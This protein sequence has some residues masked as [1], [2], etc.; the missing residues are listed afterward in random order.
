MSF[1]PGL[2]SASVT[3][4]DVMS[5]L[6]GSQ[7]GSNGSPS[8][9]TTAAGWLTL[10]PTTADGISYGAPVLMRSVPVSDVAARSRIGDNNDPV[11]YK[12]NAGIYTYLSTTTSNTLKEFTSDDECIF[13]R[14][15]PSEILLQQLAGHVSSSY[16][17]ANFSNSFHHS[18]VMR[19]GP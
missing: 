13:F 6:T 14:A 17:G 5:L 11:N 7:S 9:S 12:E 19:V 1:V 15:A 10:P 4:G 8:G 2:F 16:P 3:T 18:M